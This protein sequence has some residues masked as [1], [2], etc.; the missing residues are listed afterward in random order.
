M[1]ISNSD[2]HSITLYA[3]DESSK[4]KYETRACHTIKDSTN[5][6]YVHD[7]AFSP[8][9]KFLAAV[10]REA[11]TLSI[12]SVSNSALSDAE[13]KLIWS[14]HGDAC[15]LSFPAGVAF[16]PS[17]EWLAVANRLG[18]GISMYRS[19]D[20]SGHFESTPF[21]SISDEDL[22]SHDLAAPHGLDFSPDGQ[23]LIVVHGR[24]YKNPNPK[25]DSGLAIFT[26]RDTPDFGLDIEPRF[27]FPY[28]QHHPHS[29]AFHRSERTVVVTDCNSGVDMFDW[30]PDKK[31]LN[32]RDSFSVYK[33][34]EGPKGVAYTPDGGQLA[35]TTA[36]DEV[37]FFDVDSDTG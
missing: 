32:K 17:G 6:N 20:A 37:L 11:H 34:G 25:G 21:Q 2:A 36:L 16:H 28:G 13:P 22:S 15:G 27:V 23:F 5:L 18:T 7:V 10:G 1:A 14:A 9:G 8:C 30:L 12:F 31:Q 29:V 33:I 4:S 3:R 24:F 26:C 19:S 35:V